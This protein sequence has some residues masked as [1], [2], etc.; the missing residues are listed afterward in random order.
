MS[1][2][3]LLVLT[4]TTFLCACNE[5]RPWTDALR[6]DPASSEI[7][8]QAAPEAAERIE[9]AW[10]PQAAIA[11]DAN[12]ILYAA[13][14][15]RKLIELD[16]RQHT[17]TVRFDL[18]PYEPDLNPASAFDEP[19]GEAL[20]RADD[21]WLIVASASRALLWINLQTGEI[22]TVGKTG[23]KGASIPQEGTTLHDIDFSLFSGIGRS[24]H[25]FA[26]VLGNQ[27]FEVP[28]HGEHPDTLWHKPLTHLAGSL[29]DTDKTA[30]NDA[31]KV[32]LR[33]SEFTHFAQY[34]GYLCFW[35]PPALRA[36]KDGKIY[37]ITG[38]GYTS[39]NGNLEDF[40]AQGLPSSPK[41]VPL[42][43]SLYTP[44]WNDESAL[45]KITVDA[46]NEHSATGSLDL[47]Y[48]NAGTL[49][50]LNAWDD[51][52]LS[53]DTDAGAFWR[54]STDSGTA[55]RLFGPEDAE[56]RFQSLND[57][58]SPY[59]PHAILAPLSLV[60]WQKG[61]SALV[62][63]PTV[64][65]LSMM[66]LSTGNILPFYQ[67]SIRHIASDQDAHVWFT[68]Y[69]SLYFLSLDKDNALD[70]SYVSSF[71]KRPE[72][73]GVPCKRKTF[74]LTEAPQ[75][76]A[77]STGMYLYA[78]EASRVFGFNKTTDTLNVVH[79]NGWIDPENAETF[80][81]GGM[82]T[83]LIQFWDTNDVAEAVVLQKTGRQ[84]LFIGNL[85]SKALKLVGN[86]VSPNV[87]VSIA[88][89]EIG[90]ITA[91][92][93]TQDNRVAVASTQGVFITAEDGTWQNVS[94]C[95]IPDEESPLEALSVYGTGDDQIFVAR[96]DGQAHFCASDQT[97]HGWTSLHAERLLMCGTSRTAI[98]LADGQLCT[99][100]L[101]QN[102]AKQC[103]AP[104]AD[105]DI[106]DMTCDG[107][108][109]YL[110]GYTDGGDAII[111]RVPRSNLS[112]QTDYLGMG[113]GHPDKIE[114]QNARLGTAPGK[115]AVDA[116]RRLY[117]WMKDTC[118]VWRIDDPVTMDADTPVYRILT[119]DRLCAE[120]AA[121]TVSPDG[122]IALT[123]GKTL[124]RY[125]GQTLQS[126]GEFSGNVIELEAIGSRFAALTTAGIETWA[127]HD[128]TLA[129]KS[130]ITLD[131][132]AI[133]FAIYGD[134][135]P[136]MVQ[137]PKEN[138]VL[139]PVYQ[140]NL[141]LKLSL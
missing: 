4:C 138:A 112:K 48:P 18:S 128:I 35:T 89:D 40:Y 100:D 47:L 28:W 98:T 69:S 104:L 108:Y 134:Y 21:D 62:Y 137:S 51:D 106:Q 109:V 103:A 81:K 121:F 36:V 123:V 27:I 135:H 13:Q 88:S 10:Y 50:H 136:R 54:I 125:D 90:E 23:Q 141:V 17:Q 117:F 130:P 32:A 57:P 11:L 127:D 107:S 99:H 76:R 14:G 22:L 1:H 8:Y 20:I 7:L 45:L 101:T 80:Y 67:G 105:I 52:L 43:D 46:L 59:E 37:I 122:D 95:P 77:T 24:E 39:P 78:P 74:A 75:I 33:F 56:T 44:Y 19:W 5:S 16:T 82:P 71:F 102:T 83:H 2:K 79:E 84:Y 131:E 72:V 86:T 115:I 3:F 6:A 124:Y 58:D 60:T 64:K 34:K 9:A 91:L 118:T 41:L 73:M 12:K 42:G 116:L 53:T 96:L 113:S 85:S 114:I 129:A 132:S 25:G 133:D 139:V 30:P 15:T 55:Q 65:R 93:L 92:A 97:T 63:S 110:S 29:E 38:F 68:N 120:N 49:R 26:L 66:S 87:F 31:Q 94:N 140:N 111:R 61:A 70:L 119:D 126:S